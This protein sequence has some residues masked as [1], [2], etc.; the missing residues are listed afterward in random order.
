M[1]NN[2]N[3]KNIA[4]L[5]DADNASHDGDRPGADGPGR[6][7]P[8][9]HP[10]RLRQL[11]QAGARQVG[12]DHQPLRHPAAAAVRRLE[13]Q[14]RDR[15]GDDDRRDRPALPGQG[16][17]VRDHE[18]ATA[19]SPRWS[20]GCGRTGIVVYG[21]GSTKTP[22]AFKTAC[23]RF[24]D[25]DQLIKTAGERGR[26]T[27][28]RVRPRPRC[29]HRT[30]RTDRRG[31]QGSQARRGRLRPAPAGRPDRRQPV[32]LRRAQLRLQQPVGDVP[33]PAQLQGRA[34][35]GRQLWVKRLR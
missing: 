34:P 13:G 32:E 21:F 6:A 24:I 1:E 31:L 27:G 26:P 11:G 25:V 20:P 8:G 12:H 28:A 17:R 16:R 19:T 14:E 2:E 29:R 30:D 9:Q 35:R 15:H 33:Q 5:I 22:E 7:R 18:L 4:L 10:P 3:L 23:T